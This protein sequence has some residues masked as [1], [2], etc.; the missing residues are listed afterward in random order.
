[1]DIEKLSSTPLLHSGMKGRRPVVF[2]AL[3]F[4]TTMLM[5]FWFAWTINH[6]YQS[7]KS[8]HEYSLTAQQLQGDL[9]ILDERLAMSALMASKTG[10]QQW[11][12]RY[13]LYKPQLT[14]ALNQLKQLIDPPSQDKVASAINTANDQL[15]EIEE[16]ALKL[17]REG[18]KQQ[19]QALLEGDLY[20]SQRQIYRQ[21]AL[22]Y[23][24]PNNLYLQLERLRANI[25][26]MDEI[27]TMSAIMASVS[28]DI[29]WEQRYRTY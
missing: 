26:Y 28:G 9:L 29:S 24:Q 11:E 6:N 25:I 23:T 2:L 4:T 13:R 16:Q 20:T 18:K 7:T 17:V 8:Q 15:F 1:M 27:L 10:A 12:E 5:V 21:Q 14:T 3:L 22:N 19:A